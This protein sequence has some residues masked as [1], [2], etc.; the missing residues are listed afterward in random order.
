MTGRRWFSRVL[1]AIGVL[2][3][4][5]AVLSLVVPVGTHPP[6]ECTV[7]NESPE[8]IERVTVTVFHRTYSA[9]GLSPGGSFTF[10][11]DSAGDDHYHVE[12]EL[13]S[14]ARLVADVGYVTTGMDQKDRIEIGGDE[15]RYTTAHP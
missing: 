4:A 13:A 1:S 5:Y 12:A 9:R 15:V 6:I 3:L 8:A 14:D 11:F 2:A 10:A 7:A